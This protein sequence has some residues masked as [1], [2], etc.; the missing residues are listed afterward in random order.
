MA[1]HPKLAKTGLQRQEGGSVKDKG[2]RIK[3]K[4]LLVIFVL[5][6]MIGIEATAE[7]QNCPMDW[8]PP[9][10]G[11]PPQPVKDQKKIAAQAASDYHAKA[12]EF[13]SAWMA[14]TCAADKL[15]YAPAKAGCAA[16]GMGL[17]AAAAAKAREDRIV[18]DPF[19]P[20]YWEIYN[21]RYLSYDELGMSEFL[22]LADGPG[23]GS[24]WAIAEH[25]QVMEMLGD[26]IGVAFDRV[27]SCYQ[28]GIDLQWYLGCEVYQQN[29]LDENMHY[30]GERYLALGLHFYALAAELEQ[31][32]GDGINPAFVELL[33]EGSAWFSWAGGE[34]QQ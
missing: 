11:I 31:Y 21:G 27:M 3:D 5:L 34:F 9:P 24:M 17:A 12:M 33:Y 1:T 8:H 16:G 14:V 18:R 25:V 7:A 19:D 26:R 20:N 13:F 15:G 2:K 4:L 32:I 30:F 22:A 6:T 23:A 28:A 29:W 10:C